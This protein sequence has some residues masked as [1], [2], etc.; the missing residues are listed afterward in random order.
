M[1]P[2]GKAAKLL[3]GGGGSVA[4]G[5]A[6]FSGVRRDRGRLFAP[7]RTDGLETTSSTEQARLEADCEDLLLYSAPEEAYLYRSE[8]VRYLARGLKRLPRSYM[9]L[10]A[11][12]PWIL[13]WILHAL[14]LLGA[15]GR[16]PSDEEAERIAGFLRRCQ[17]PTGGFGGGPGQRAHLAPTYA[18]VMSLVVLGADKGFA[19]VDRQGMYDFLMSI[20]VL[21]N[22][23]L[24]GGFAVTVGGEV[25]T[26]GT[27]T[28]LAVASMLNLVTEELAEG[29]ADFVARNQTYEGGIG[30]EPGNEAHGGYTYCGLAALAI[31]GRTDAVDLGALL[32]WATQR[33][34]SVE[35]GFQGRTNKLVDSCYSWWVGGVMELLQRYVRRPGA[36]TKTPPQHGGTAKASPSQDRKGLDSKRQTPATAPGLPPRGHT[37]FNA[38]KLQEYILMC[39]QEGNG[40]LKDKP[41]KWADYYHTCYSLSGLSMAQQQTRSDGKGGSVRVG[42]VGVEGQNNVCETDPIYNVGPERVAKAKA[43]FS[44]LPLPKTLAERAKAPRNQ[45][46]E[47]AAK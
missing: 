11:S 28:C 25:D 8:H 35:G 4:S 29:C 27:Y 3:G 16:E 39:C 5:E 21:G 30:A 47:G 42:V 38:R 24:R 33:Q 45:T 44:K 23:P 17:A 46:S 41:E 40:G 15:L 34:M 36:K 13:Y 26:R 18:G 6:G 12:R 2:T 1:K 10:D 20:K 7:V 14:E 9:S 32:R 43:Y 37:L 31:L 22:G 19:M